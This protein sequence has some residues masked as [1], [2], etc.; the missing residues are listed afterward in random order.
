MVINNQLVTY[1]KQRDE[2]GNNFLHYSDA[3]S[4]LLQLQTKSYQSHYT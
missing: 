3:D 4:H 2:Q 1:V